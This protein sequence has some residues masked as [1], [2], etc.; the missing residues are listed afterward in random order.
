M[1]LKIIGM[2][3]FL[4]KPEV[5][6][7]ALAIVSSPDNEYDGLS[8]S[9]VAPFIATEDLYE[10]AMEAKKNN[11]SISSLFVFMKINDLKRLIKSGYLSKEE[12]KYLVIFLDKE[13]I[14]QLMREK[15]NSHDYSNFVAYLPFT[16][17]KVLGEMMLSYALD[18]HDPFAFYA[19]VD[20]EAKEQLVGLVMD[21]K[22]PKVN[23]NLLYPFLDNKDIE[24]LFESYLKE[25]GKP[26]TIIDKSKDKN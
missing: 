23:L 7:L 1:N 21:K 19:F 9:D 17:K 18:G 24:A 8:L 15:T 14:N 25:K 10:V 6:K 22:A 20:E 12:M 11:K 13:D 16:D 3:P 26:I 5:K 4:K 2:I